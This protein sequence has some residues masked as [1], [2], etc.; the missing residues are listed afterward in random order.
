MD[1][2]K[3]PCEYDNSTAEHINYNESLSQIA[4]KVNIGIKDKLNTI[5]T[6]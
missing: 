1:K 3:T 2:E 4:E 5:R 6:L